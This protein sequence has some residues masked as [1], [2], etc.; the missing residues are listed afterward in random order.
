MKTI[1][2][3]ICLFFIV[4]SISGCSLFTDKQTYAVDS[5]MIATDLQ[6]FQLYFD[7]SVA[8]LTDAQKQ[9]PP[10]FTDDEWKTITNFCGEVN[11]LIAQEKTIA[12]LQLE[13]LII[14]TK[15]FK[16]RNNMIKIFLNI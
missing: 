15:K 3:I 1:A 16:T 5:I 12:Q 11:F 8:K 14:T 10:I 6:N 4:I 7:K 9:N 2:Y 13:I